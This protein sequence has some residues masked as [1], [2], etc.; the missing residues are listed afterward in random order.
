MA[1]FDVHW[2][3]GLTDTGLESWAAVEA[4][5]SARLDGAVEYGD[6]EN[7][8]RGAPV[9]FWGPARTAAGHAADG[10]IWRRD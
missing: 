10:Q 9:L 7:L 2:D 8:D 4:A 1:T 6:S 3:D 5:V